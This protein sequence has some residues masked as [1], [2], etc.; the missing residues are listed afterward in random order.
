MYAC[1]QF[2][3]M[4]GK[5]HDNIVNIFQF[6]KYVY[7]KKRKVQQEKKKKNKI[8]I[9][10]GEKKEFLRIDEINMKVTLLQPGIVIYTVEV[11]L[12]C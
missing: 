7:L 3:L 8:L 9:P 6:K 11:N 12:H 4:Y 1:G 10:K 5:N 2:M